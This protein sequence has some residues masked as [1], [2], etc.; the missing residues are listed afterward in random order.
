MT[1]EY[2]EAIKRPYLLAARCREPASPS[3]NHFDGLT[4]DEAVHGSQGKSDALKSIVAHGGIRVVFV[5]RISTSS[6]IRRSL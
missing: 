1:L 4:D 3:I 2:D 6:F 5:A